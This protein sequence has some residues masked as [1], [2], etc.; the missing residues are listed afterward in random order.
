MKNV[1]VKPVSSFHQ[2]FERTDV[3]TEALKAE[4][5]VVELR[6]TIIPAKGFGSVFLGMLQ[7]DVNS[8]VG[9]PKSSFKKAK[10]GDTETDNYGSFHVFY[11]KATKVEAIE[12][13]LSQEGDVKLN[14]KNIMG[15]KYE[16]LL[17][18]FKDLDS[19]TVEKK[20]GLKSVKLGLDVRTTDNK[21]TSLIIASSEYIKKLKGR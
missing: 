5:G 19:D 16:D 12:I 10:E 15:M 2:C 9:D 3:S 18:V 1:V 6:A 4:K 14:K 8:R 13:F 11:N 20:E 7:K 17:K 21:P